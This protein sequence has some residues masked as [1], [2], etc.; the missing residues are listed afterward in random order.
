MS[1]SKSLLVLSLLVL[2]MFSST[3][4]A[5]P[6][7][8]YCP[9]KARE[10]VK[11][12]EDPLEA[13]DILDLAWLNEEAV[14]VLEGVDDRN[15]EVLWRLARSRVNIGE[16]LP[17]KEAEP[18][19]EQAYEEAKAAVEKDDTIA[20]AHLMVAI[21]AG[22]MALMRG[23]FKASGLVKEGRR[24]ALLAVTLSDSIPAAQYVLGR[25]HKKLM[26]KS[27]LARKVAGLSFASNDSVS[28]Y[29]DK[30]IEIS[31]G[32]MISCYVEYGDFL[33]K[34]DDKEKAKEMLEKA[35]E[36]PLRDEQDKKNQDRAIELLK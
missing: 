15:A 25:T 19:Y 18:F 16:N 33:L 20:D 32:N 35:L 1:I 23:P 31:H 5:E 26:E 21:A 9:D 34:H 4:I 8:R 29:F 12:I 24:H 36:L 13:A 6:L 3:V 22:R 2:F 28:Y 7:K 30:S 10:A 17:E 27:G 14:A 11:T